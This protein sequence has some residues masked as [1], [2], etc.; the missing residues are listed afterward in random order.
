[1]SAILKSGGYVRWLMIILF[2]TG[3]ILNYV[4]RNASGIMAQ[5]IIKDLNIT[6]K[7]YSYITGAFYCWTY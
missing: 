6:P 5:E 7:E 3:V 4:D 1:M 2:A